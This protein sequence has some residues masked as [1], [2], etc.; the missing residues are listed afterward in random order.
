MPQRICAG[1]AGNEDVVDVWITNRKH[2]RGGRF[3]AHPSPL[4]RAYIDDEQVLNTASDDV[5]A[6]E[7][8]LASRRRGHVGQGL[9]ATVDRAGT[10]RHE[11]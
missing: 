10:P 9:N 11:Q 1:T 7:A 5:L 3:V 8:D 2:I 6:R 4:G